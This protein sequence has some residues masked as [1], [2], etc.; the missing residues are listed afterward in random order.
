[1]KMKMA[2][3]PFGRQHRI[4]HYFHRCIPCVR[5]QTSLVRAGCVDGK[6]L[7]FLSF[8]SITGLIYCYLHN[9]ILLIRLELI[10]N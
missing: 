3:L 2:L 1:M 4:I 9:L 8:F 5:V 6:L 7:H 10:Q